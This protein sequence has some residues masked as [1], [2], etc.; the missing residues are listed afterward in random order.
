[1]YLQTSHRRQVLMQPHPRAGGCG[2]VHRAV[3]GRAEEVAGLEVETLADFAMV[4]PE[5]SQATSIMLISG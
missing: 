5:F 1:M 4:Q 3:P 2:Q